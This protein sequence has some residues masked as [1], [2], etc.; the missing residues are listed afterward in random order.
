[1]K[2]GDAIVANADIPDEEKDAILSSFDYLRYSDSRFVPEYIKDIN[3]SE[4]KDI[5]G[6]DEDTQRID[7]TYISYHNS[8][9][10]EKVTDISKYSGFIEVNNGYDFVIYIQGKE[11]DLTEQ[12]GNYEE[13]PEDSCLIVSCDD[14]DFYITHLSY[15]YYVKD[16]GK[17]YKYVS[18]DGYAFMH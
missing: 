4:L 9:Y 6:F 8:D 5:F 11:Y 7:Y 16:S 17:V 3:V 18:L 15:S 13:D 14:A 10:E 2:K 12:L 1:M